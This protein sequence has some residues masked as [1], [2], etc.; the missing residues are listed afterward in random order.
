PYPVTRSMPDAPVYR[1]ACGGAWFQVDSANGAVLEK[2]DS[3]RRSYRWLY[4]AL[5]T[6]DFPAF[7]S[8]PPL[9]T[10]VIMLLCGLGFAFSITA[11]V[12]A[13]RRLSAKRRPR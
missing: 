5:H 7:V 6:L 3:S 8:R 13:W 9:R 10:T 1:F 4:A 12:I 11:V 2:M